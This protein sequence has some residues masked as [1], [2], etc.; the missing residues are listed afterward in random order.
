MPAFSFMM[1]TSWAWHYEVTNTQVFHYKSQRMINK[2][3]VKLL[4][5]ETTYRG[6]L[7][8]EGESEKEILKFGI[9]IWHIDKHGVLLT[10]RKREIDR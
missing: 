5:L 8:Y 1:I 3:D 2:N 10:A 7:W 9:S 4:L 6:L